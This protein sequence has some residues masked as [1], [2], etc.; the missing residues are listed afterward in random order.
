M[1]VGRSV[2][3]AIDEFEAGDGECAMLHAC[4]AVDG[5]A[6]KVFPDL[7]N[8]RRFTTLLR[9]NY[10]ILGPMGAPGINLVETRFPVKIPGAL[11]DGEEPDLADL[12]YSIHRCSHGH[13]DELPAGFELISDVAGPKR[14][15][16]MRFT[17]GTVQMSDRVIFGLLACA[18][19]SPV[20]WN[21]NI[22]EGYHLTYGA[23]ATM[24]IHEWWGKADKFPEI[25]ALDPPPSVKLDFTNW[26]EA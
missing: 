10:N 16:R 23:D 22:P 20:N 24:Y 26:N 12:I 4:N 15:T 25:V 19:L 9:N 13:G 8:R 18:V 11:V 5:T 1:N 17:N 7:G 2:K 21:Q 6:K 3:K 14:H